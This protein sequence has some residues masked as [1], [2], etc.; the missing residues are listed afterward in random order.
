MNFILK[1]FSLFFVVLVSQTLANQYSSEQQ[2]APSVAIDLD[3][4]ED[5]DLIR[6]FDFIIDHAGKSSSSSDETIPSYSSE[7]NNEITQKRNTRSKTFNPQ[8]S[9][10]YHLDCI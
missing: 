3:S 4:K 9:M 8:T 10:N 6:L 5:A 7:I 1:L 2:A